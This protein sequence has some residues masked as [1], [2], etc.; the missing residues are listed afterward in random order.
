MATFQK[1][2]VNSNAISQ[3]DLTKSNNSASS[4][5]S[6]IQGMID[7]LSQASLA[8]KQASIDKAMNDS[9][10]SY[11]QQI[12]AA[13]QSYQPMRN[14]AS[15]QGEQNLQ[16]IKEQQAAAGNWR[17]GGNESAQTAARAATSNQ[18]AGYNQQ[19]QD[20][21]NKLKQAI[22][23]VKTN[24]GYD[25]TQALNDTEASKLSNQINQANTDRTYDY[26]VGTAL[27]V[28]NGQ[29]TL[30]GKQT[31]AQVALQNAQTTYQN[32][33]NQGYPQEEALKLAQMAA[34]LQGTNLQNNYQSTVN[35]YQPQLLQNQVTSGSLANA[36]QATTNQYQPQ[37]LQNQVTSGQLANTAQ[38]IQ[39]QYQPQIY[40]GQIDST[41]LQNDY[42]SL[43]NA[44]YPAQQAMDLAVKQANIDQ[45][46]R[47]LDIAQ[48]NANT[49]AYSASRAGSGSSSANLSAQKY[50]DQ[51][52]SQ[53]SFAQSMQGIQNMANNGSTRSDILKFINS[54][55]GDLQANGV[56][57]QD[58]YNWASKNFTWDKDSS[59]NWYN[60]A[61]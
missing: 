17:S 59:G 25:S 47:Q 16:A 46:N 31:D 15:L 45:G 21:V 57:V 51:Q 6:D 36:N 12:D 32:L 22:E 18:I 7:K 41:K 2:N 19:Q 1:Y 55:A 9:V 44:G 28:L 34:S 54:N 11:N 56:S 24:A 37:I 10:N 42:Q 5:T 20:Y 60:T 8:A 40:Q 61:Q 49:S 53:Q 27:G 26:N 4:S 38:S 13:P 58:L 50:A 3:P 33:V 23:Q 35:Q 29:Q 30:Q 52:A 48:Q 14:Q 43:V 39:N